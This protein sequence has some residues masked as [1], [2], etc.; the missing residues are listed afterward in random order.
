MKQKIQM[1]PCNYAHLTFDKCT[2]NIQ[3]RKDSLLQ[4]VLGKLVYACRKLKLEPWLSPCTNINSK[5][6]KDLNIRHK[7]LKLVQGRTGSALE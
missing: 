6:I 4:T 1:N 7:T 5:W 3:W 2:K